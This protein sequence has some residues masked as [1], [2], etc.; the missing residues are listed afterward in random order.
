MASTKITAAPRPIAV[1][2]F[3]DRPGTSTSRGRT[4]GPCSRRRWTSWRAKG[5]VAARA[6][7]SSPRSGSGPGPLRPDEQPDQEEGARR[8]H[9]QAVRR[10][11]SRRTSPGG[12]IVTPSSEPEPRSSRKKLTE[13]D[14]A[15]AETVAEPVEERLPGG[16]A[17]AN[18][19][20]RPIT[21]QFVMMSPTNTDSCLRPRR[22]RPA[23]SGRPRSPATR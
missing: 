8:E 14:H 7:S 19:S 20:A 11:T 13:Q 10:S 5:S 6:W 4:R 16:L 2:T 9:H 15:V 21:M 1:S 22:G 23:G 18:A 12:T 17:I 3:F